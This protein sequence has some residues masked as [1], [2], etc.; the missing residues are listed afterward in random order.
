VAGIENVR[1]ALYNSFYADW[2]DRTPLWFDNESHIPPENSPWV[3]VSSRAFTARQRT[4]GVIGQRKFI[5]SGVM[6]IEVFV[7][8][9]SGT[10]ELYQYVDQAI[11][12]FE[13]KRIPLDDIFIRDIQSTDRG[14]EG[15]WLSVL[16]QIN[17]DYEQT[18]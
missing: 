17:F 3:R 2:A 11:D 6:F 15:K 8:V 14:A 5:N 16:I 7:P 18:K 1:K 9:G 4:L 12:V 10:K 13:G